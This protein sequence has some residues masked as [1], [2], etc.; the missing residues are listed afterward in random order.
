[1]HD[2]RWIYMTLAVLMLFI[3][4]INGFLREMSEFNVFRT[5]E[6]LFI[7]LASLLFFYAAFRSNR[8][9]EAER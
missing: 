9:L 1:M 2:S 4:T 3:A 6:W 7:M 5:V 8:K